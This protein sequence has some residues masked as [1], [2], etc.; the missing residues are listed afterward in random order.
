LI[1]TA[2]SINGNSRNSK[3]NRRMEVSLRK[4]RLPD[5]Y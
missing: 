3:R 5:S 4:K 2:S 1:S